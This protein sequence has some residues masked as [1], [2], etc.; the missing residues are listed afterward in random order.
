MILKAAWKD[1]MPGFIEAMVQVMNRFIVYE[2]LWEL[3]QKPSLEEKYKKGD[4]GKTK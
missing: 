2:R 4:K 3:Q 1:G